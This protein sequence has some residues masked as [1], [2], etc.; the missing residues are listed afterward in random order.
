MTVRNGGF[1]G[2][3]YHN[4]FE[5]PGGYDEGSDSPSASEGS[6]CSKRKFGGLN[7]TDQEAFGVS[8][9]VLPLSGLSSSE[10]KELIRRLRQ[11]L[12]QIRFF[13]KSFELSRSL[14]VSGSSA[15]S[16][17]KSRCSTGPGKSVNPITAP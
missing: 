17:G 7:Y 11:E 9:M 6:N 1:L 8:K 14:A 10:R 3:Y 13:Q 16:F 5:A 4:S 15:K 2:D 12:E